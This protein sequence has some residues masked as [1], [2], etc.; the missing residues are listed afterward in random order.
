MIYSKLDIE[1]L[2]G[3]HWA[4]TVVTPLQ[5]WVNVIVLTQ[6]DA[7]LC[8][9]LTCYASGQKKHQPFGAEEA[10]EPPGV[11]PIQMG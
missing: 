5:G 4:H 2:F 8:P 1:D 3:M 9:G 11:L 6:G 10:R 7:S